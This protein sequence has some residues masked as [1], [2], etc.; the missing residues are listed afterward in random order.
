METKNTCTRLIQC[1]KIH[2]SCHKRKVDMDIKA[3]IQ[4]D[5]LAD[6][7]SNLIE[8]GARVFAGIKFYTVGLGNDI[9]IDILVQ[10]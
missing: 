2:L 7:L 5:Q 9:E 4:K 10:D 6:F 1:G 3:R 8:Q